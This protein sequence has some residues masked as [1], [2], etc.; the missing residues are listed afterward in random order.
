V[1]NISVYFLAQGE[2]S[3]DSVMGWLTAFI[4]A[5]K[6]T[7]DFAIYD[8]RLSDP[9]KAALVGALRG[10]A[11][12]PACKFAF[13]MTATNRFNQMLLSARIRL[14]LERAHLFSR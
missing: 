6:E 1:D 8:M 10:R 14:R 11:P 4:G 12:K 3:A 2:Q 7:L 13:A 9:L 5:A